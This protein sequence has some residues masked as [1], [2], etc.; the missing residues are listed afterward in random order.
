MKLSGIA[1]QATFRQ[2]A[3]LGEQLVPFVTFTLD[4]FGSERTMWASDWP[5]CKLG[6]ALTGWVQALDEILAPY[7]EDGEREL[8]GPKPRAGSTG[9]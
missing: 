4:A 2:A 3:P 6:T 8:S 5:V 9:V 7:P 1:A